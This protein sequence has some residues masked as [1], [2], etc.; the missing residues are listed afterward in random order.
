M[1]LL[2]TIIVMAFLMTCFPSNAMESEGSSIA[3]LLYR[4]RSAFRFSDPKAGAGDPFKHLPMD[5]KKQLLRNILETY[6]LAE[7]VRKIRQLRRVCQGWDT[8]LRESEIL[9]YVLPS[10]FYAKDGCEEVL[11]KK[12]LTIAECCFLR[13]MVNNQLFVNR[14]ALQS[15][16]DLVESSAPTGKILLLCGPQGVG[17]TSIIN[18]VA[19]NY[20]L[21]TKCF[22]V[23]QLN[24]SVSKGGLQ[25]LTEEFFDNK[26]DSLYVI[27]DIELLSQ[28]IPEHIVFLVKL[29][30]SSLRN[31]V[32]LCSKWF[33][34]VEKSLVNDNFCLW[35]NLFGVVQ[36]TSPS[37][38]ERRI[39]FQ[40]YVDHL[41]R[42]SLSATF[43]ESVLSEEL[44][45]EISQGL[46]NFIGRYSEGFTGSYIESLVSDIRDAVL[47]PTEQKITADFI[48]RIVSKYRT[49][50]EELLLWI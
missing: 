15:I 50:T 46:D 49:D 18:L 41:L 42:N 22:Y 24:S 47:K 14:R 30:E 44:F 7:K 8:M 35:N 29:F 48:R 20:G 23:S 11:T 32:I 40:L 19:K 36:V 45:D 6:H 31:V 33:N 26:K 3:K 13:G 17:K 37:A 21:K 43:D 34:D 1:K 2:K 28:N 5:L 12:S 16:C 27:D 10:F 25:K 4:V 39:I 9:R 38:G